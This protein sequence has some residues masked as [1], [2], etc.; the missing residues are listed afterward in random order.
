MVELSVAAVGESG[1]T[2]ELPIEFN[3]ASWAE[4]ASRLSDE[5]NHSDWSD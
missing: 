2:F 1:M 5:P 3:E 4:S